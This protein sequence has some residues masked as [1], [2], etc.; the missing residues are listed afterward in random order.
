MEIVL[1]IWNC[2][3]LLAFFIREGQHYSQKKDLLDRI[4]CRDYSNFKK[5]D[6]KSKHI[7]PE[8]PGHMTDEQMVAAEKEQE[9]ARK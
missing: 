1:V 4:M 5:Y 6:K 8:F 9:N 7:K 2:I 3:L